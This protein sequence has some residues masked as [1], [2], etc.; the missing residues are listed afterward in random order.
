MKPKKERDGPKEDLGPSEEYKTFERTLDVV[1]KA[2]KAD[3][4]RQMAELHPKRPK[5]ARDS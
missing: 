3:I 5:K 4:D 2:S 1:L